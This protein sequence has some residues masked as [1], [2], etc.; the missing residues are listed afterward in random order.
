MPAPSVGSNNFVFDPSI[1][2]YS[3]IYNR[4]SRLRGSQIISPK[5]TVKG[6]N[7]NQKTAGTAFYKNPYGQK[8]KTGDLSGGFFSPSNLNQT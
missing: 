7:W 4:P 2:Q 8:P 1:F 3:G 6:V 5:A